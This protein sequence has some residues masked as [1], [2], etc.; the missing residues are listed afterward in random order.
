MEASNENAQAAGDT[1][2]GSSRAPVCA[3]YCHHP[4]RW[5]WALLSTSS[6]PGPEWLW[7]PWITSIHWTRLTGLPGARPGGEGMDTPALL[8]TEGVGLIQPPGLS[9]LEAEPPNPLPEFGGH[10]AS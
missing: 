7:D 9:Y 3:D 6:F 4:H 8:Y 5:L 2:L 1:A 10:S